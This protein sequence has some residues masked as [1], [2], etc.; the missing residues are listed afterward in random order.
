[1]EVSMAM[2]LE[3]ISSKPTKRGNAYPTRPPTKCKRRI[4]SYNITDSKR[5]KKKRQVGCLEK[6]SKGERSGSELC[7]HKTNAER[8]S[9]TML[10]IPE[11]QAQHS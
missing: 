3:E 11:E 1:M 4:G 10:L 6:N 5:T 8:N 2:V 7:K 9:M